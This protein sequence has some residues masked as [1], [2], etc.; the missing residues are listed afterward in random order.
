MLLASIHRKISA[1]E[2]KWNE[3]ALTSTVF[4]TLQY[5]PSS[6]FC[7]VLKAAVDTNFPFTGAGEIER[8]EFWPNWDPTDTTNSSFVEPDV[9][10]RFSDD[11]DLIIEAKPT[12]E[13]LQ[14]K[15]QWENQIQAYENVYGNE[16]KRLLYL[17]IVGLNK[18][19][20]ENIK[21]QDI[22]KC[23]L[24]D[25]LKVIETERD[26]LTSKTDISDLTRRT[27]A[28]LEDTIKGFGLFGY[29]HS[30]NLDGQF[31]RKTI[32]KKT[33]ELWKTYLPTS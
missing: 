12:E 2:V 10:I 25:I 30:T 9:F 18:R 24:K 29:Y 3:D 19:T 14:L 22:V 28:I 1:S 11:V 23:Y 5:L 17:A 4:G 13:K 27:T 32:P 31:I 6:V 7:A 26:I 20:I 33:L 21:K 8:V 15:G 16:G